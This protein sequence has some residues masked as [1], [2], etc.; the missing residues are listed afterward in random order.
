MQRSVQR[1]LTKNRLQTLNNVRDAGLELC[2]GGIIGLGESHRDL[3]SMAMDLRALKTE[4][5]PHN[6]LACYRRHSAT[7]SQ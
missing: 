4:S 6:F 2:S 1:T 3:V 7:E 5:I